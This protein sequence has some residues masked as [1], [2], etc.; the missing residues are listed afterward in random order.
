MPKEPHGKALRDV[1]RE[2]ILVV[3]AET[4]WKIGG[5]G[6]AAEILELER[7]TLHAKMKKLGISRHG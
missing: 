4:K 3:L 6:G 2:Q 1:E 5:R 7:T